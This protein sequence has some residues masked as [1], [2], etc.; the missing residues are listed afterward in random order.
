MLFQTTTFER[1]FPAA[2]SGGGLLL[3]TSFGFE[4]RGKRYFDVSVPGRPRIEQGMTVIALLEKPNDWGPDSLLGWIDCSEGS[5]VCD[6][7]SKLFGIFLLNAYF[8]LMFPIW[9]YAVI[10]T[11]S[12]ADIAAFFVAA[13][14]SGFACRF[15]YLSVKAFLVKRALSTVRDFINHSSAEITANTA[16]KRDAPQAARPL[17]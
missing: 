6:S 9:A 13:V 12:S 10:A 14:F 15:L 16:V 3:E 1:L 4:S 7:P 2:Y 17:P 5:L 8:A 11:P